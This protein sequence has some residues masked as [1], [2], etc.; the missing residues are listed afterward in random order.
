MEL[1]DYNKQISLKRTVK[2]KKKFYLST[3]FS[4]ELLL[5]VFSE[6]A[7]TAKFCN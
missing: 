2:N 4:S 1:W 5:E 3:Y 7:R 6:S